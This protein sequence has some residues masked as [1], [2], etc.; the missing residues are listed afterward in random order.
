MIEF[1]VA[2]YYA[3]LKLIQLGR[4][5]KLWAAVSSTNF[6][7]IVS[8]ISLHLTITLVFG[9][10]VLNKNFVIPLGIS[11]IIVWSTF[12]LIFFIRKKKYIDIEATYDSNLKKKRKAY[13]IFGIF[14]L[15][16]I[17]VFILS[18]H[19]LSQ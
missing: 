14:W 18:S 2:L 4:A 6:I 8:V 7:P 17:C 9:R 19:N 3:H 10:N 15:W 1:Y 12:N 5:G 16:V 11:L 13:L